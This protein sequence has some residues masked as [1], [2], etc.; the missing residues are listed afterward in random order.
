MFILSDP[1][2]LE[3]G[4]GK[5]LKLQS[6][7]VILQKHRLT[8]WQLK[9]FTEQFLAAAFKNTEMFLFM[10]ISNQNIQCFLSFEY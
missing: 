3:D 4:R 2:I 6:Y 5:K 9:C 8:A 7:M 10:F 1:K